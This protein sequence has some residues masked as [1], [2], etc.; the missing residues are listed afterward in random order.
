MGLNEVEAAQ[1]LGELAGE[2]RRAGSPGLTP[3]AATWFLAT[4]A[5]VRALPEL[6]PSATV[7]APR[8]ARA[9]RSLSPNAWI[10]RSID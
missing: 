7:P 6:A 8:R 2:R 9:G 4:L 1:A 10:R 3:V 5:Q